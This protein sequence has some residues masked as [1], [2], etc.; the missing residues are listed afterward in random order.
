MLIT[1]HI[2]RYIVCDLCVSNRT[3]NGNVVFQTPFL[4][5]AQTPT[6]VITG[7]RQNCSFQKLEHEHPFH[8]RMLA[9]YTTQEKVMQANTKELQIELQ[10]N[11]L[12]L[13]CAHICC[14]CSRFPLVL[15]LI[16]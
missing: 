10:F 9:F 8:I 3:N 14:A 16:I 12:L 6:A 13:A 11:K 15:F 7:N 2:A 4:H 5:H 1:H